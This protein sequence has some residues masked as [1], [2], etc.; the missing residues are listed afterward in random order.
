[1][2]D[3][4]AVSRDQDSIQSLKLDFEYMHL[5]L[6]ASNALRL[7]CIPRF[8]KALFAK[9]FSVKSTIPTLSPY[10]YREMW[11]S[12]V[13]TLLIAGFS[14]NLNYLPGVRS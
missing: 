5:S 10:L 14:D 6:Q 13:F 8:G 7:F 2:R 4:K 1:M 11:K 9:L 12:L 3:E